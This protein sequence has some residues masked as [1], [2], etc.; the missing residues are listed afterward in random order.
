MTLRKLHLSGLL[1]LGIIGCTA[2]PTQTLTGTLSDTMCGA[3][4]MMKDMSAAACTRECVKAG[5]DYALVSGGK[6]Y[7]LKGNFSQLDKFAGQ[8]V[9]VTGKLSGKVMTVDDISAPKA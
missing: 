6:V 8:A 3:K 1:I 5:A 7:T 2:Q 9:K 4:H